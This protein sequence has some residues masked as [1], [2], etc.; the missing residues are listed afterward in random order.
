MPK[1]AIDYSKTIIYKIE[2]TIDKSL[3]YVG[4]TTDYTKRKYGH[5]TSCICEKSKVYH[6]KVYQMIR[7]NG[8][9]NMFQMLEIKKFP[10]QDSKEACAEEERVRVELKATMN[11]VRAFVFEKEKEKKEYRETHKKEKQEQDREYREA[12]QEKIKAN[13][14]Q[15]HIDNRE[16]LNAKSQAYLEEHRDEINEQKRNHYQEIKDKRH[17]KNKIQIICECG[18]TY[19]QCNKARHLK[20]QFHLDNI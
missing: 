12:N 1:Q 10:C 7:D 8:G 4:H 15:Y 2:H 19:T 14:K 18:M 3:L 16:R 6:L 13:K 17:E 20:T 9:W 5:K 11:D